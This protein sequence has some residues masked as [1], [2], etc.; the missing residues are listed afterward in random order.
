MAAINAFLF[1]GQGSQSVGMGREL[2]ETIPSA[3][4]LLD[5][6]GDILGFN[7]KQIMFDGPP[8]MLTDTRFA[9]P[10]IYTCSAMHLEKARQE[11]LEYAFVAGHSLG[12]YNALYAAG[13][14]SF[15]DGLKLVDARA[16]AMATE[17]GKGTKIAVLGL[18]EE[19]LWPYV[20]SEPDVVIACL[21]T[22]TQIV[23]S[24]TI[25]GIERIGR[26]LEGQGVKVRK[27]N[28]SAAF[29]SPQMAK[30]AAVMKEMIEDQPFSTP[31]CQVVSN[32]TGKP[33]K[34]AAELKA[35]L[36]KHMTG[37]VRWYE[38]VLSMER[39]GVEQFY[40]CGNGHILR[41][42]NDAITTRPKCLSI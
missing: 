7:L 41:R 16:R 1:P 21:N 34:D 5:E 6:V 2:Y 20:A 9:Q 36:I 25:D 19:K 4:I 29:H 15:V 37:Q 38:S 26:K 13:V 40:E 27:L 8:E 22:K 12:E 17:N 11:G 35:N 14:F 18:E 28:V 31:C 30:A 10:A 39:A 23:L 24:G 33:T 32:V 42:M 3:R